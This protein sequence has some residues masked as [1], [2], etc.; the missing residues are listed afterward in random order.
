MIWVGWL[1]TDRKR[2]GCTGWIQ[3]G[4]PGLIWFRQI[5]S[6]LAEH[7][8]DKL[9]FSWQDMIWTDLLLTDWS[10]SGQADSVLAWNNQFGLA[11]GKLDTQRTGWMITSGIQSGHSDWIWSGQAG[12]IWSW[13][14]CSWLAGHNF[15][16]LARSWLNIISM[17]WQGAGHG[18]TK[19]L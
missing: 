19:C 14:I 10:R 4:W 8:Q 17:D 2:S 15:D 18:H 1:F 11:L 3:S 6:Q 12:M 13:Q 16:R 5:S 9:A 7:D